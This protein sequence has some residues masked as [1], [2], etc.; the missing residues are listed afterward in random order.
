MQ[1]VRRRLQAVDFIPT[2]RVVGSLV[3]VFAAVDGVIGEPALLYPL[4]PPP[5]R[6]RRDAI[7]DE[8]LALNE[9]PTLPKPPRETLPLLR[10]GAYDG[11]GR[12]PT[13]SDAPDDRH[14]LGV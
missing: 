13:D 3:P 6:I 8:A 9:R 4:L 14:A 1:L 12:E 11:D 2:E 7:H 10:P 5:A